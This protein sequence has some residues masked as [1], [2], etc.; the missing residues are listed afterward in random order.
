M[1]C[2]CWRGCCL[3][4]NYKMDNQ[5]DQSNSLN[6][7]ASS[8]KAS[9]FIGQLDIPCNICGAS[10]LKWTVLYKCMHIVYLCT[11]VLVY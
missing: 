11:S 1:K 4:H 10:N 6:P 2:W 8:G 7:I 5:T 3:F 9:G